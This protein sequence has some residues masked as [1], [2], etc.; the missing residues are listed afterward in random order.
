MKIAIMQPYIFPYLGYFQMIK[1]VDKFILLDDV[2]FIKRGWI[3]RNRILI[4]KQAFKITIPVL[5]A[6]QNKKINQL[7]ISDETV[8]REKLLSTIHMA[9]KK[10]P[11]FKSAFAVVEKAIECEEQNLSGFIYN[12]LV[13]FCDYLEVTTE[14]IPSSSH[15]PSKGLKAQDR[16]IDICVQA[17]G[18]KYVN[19]IGGR[20]LYSFSSFQE[21]SIE[22]NFF[23]MSA[24]L[25]YV[26]FEEKNYVPF[27][28]I[29]D[30]IMFNT[31]K[32][33][34]ALMEKYSL[35]TK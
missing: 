1:A 12:S 20:E 8:W 7:Q 30:V 13:S 15:Y 29:I 32:E 35:H 2:N 31:T 25:S 10:A 22:L 6:S 11:C 24:D 9:Y 17:G 23:E 19:A 21:K 4:N 18:E 34:S 14:I 28:S 33:I 16:I 3:N 26:Q 27:L 5:K